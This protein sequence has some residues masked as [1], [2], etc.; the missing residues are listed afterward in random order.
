MSKMIENLSNK[1]IKESE[2]L[3]DAYLWDQIKN[4]IMYSRKFDANEWIIEEKPSKMV[5]DSDS[6]EIRLT[7]Y[8]RLRPKTQIELF[9]P[10]I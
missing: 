3:F 6:E 2:I 9:F 8:V 10:Y 4:I 1:L 7:R 5:H